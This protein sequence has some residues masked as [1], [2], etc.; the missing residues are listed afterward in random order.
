MAPGRLR[1]LD[2]V[3]ALAVLAVLANH[4]GLTFLPGGFIGV[5]VFFVL[6]GFLITSLL[7][8]ELTATGRIG[9]GAF[10]ARRAR[11]LL[12]AALAMIIAVLAARP[13]FPPD[14]VA[15]L[16]GDAITAAL[17][18]S[19]WRFAL[20]GT[21][22]F[23][24]GGTP[25]P[26]QHTWSLAVEEQFYVV[27]PLLLL[28]CRAVRRRRLLAVALTGAA[29]SA[30]VTY[31]LTGAA[32]PGRVYFG[33]DTRAQELLTGAALAALLAPTWRWLGGGPR[34]RRSPQ[35][36]GRRPLPLLLSLGG[37]AALAA[38]ATT[39]SGA[40]GEFRHGLL[41]G[42]ALATAA[43]LAGV[44]LDSGQP[45]ARLLSA[46]PLAGIG[47]ISYGLYLWHWPVFLVLDGERS[48][49]HGY[50][51]AALRVA[52]TGALAGASFVLIERPAQR[53]R[54][55]ASQVLPAAAAGVA[56][57][58]VVTVCTVP[59][60]VPVVPVAAPGQPDVIPATANAAAP[61]QSTASPPP[62]G[63]APHAT[64]RPGGALHVDVF[65]DSIAWTLMHYLPPTPGMRFTDHTVLG[66]G[67]VTGGP[68]R[69]FGSQ[70]PDSRTCDE[71]PRRW[72][73][74]LDADHPAEAL[75]VVGRWETM[76]HQYQGQWM[77][78]GE[79]RYD[80]FLAGLLSE[81][82]TLLGSTGARVVVATEPYN[83]RGE[84]PDGSLYPEDEPERVTAWNR[85][86]RG[87]VTAHPGTRV[88]DLNHE[89]C[90]NGTFTWTVDGLQVRSDGVHLTPD[91]VRWLTPWLVGQLSQD[92]SG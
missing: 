34:S 23:S 47:R 85:L 81:A 53:V 48:G 84:Q 70:F 1:A 7:Y 45:V 4:A 71:W 65:G 68:Y 38:I 83:R 55:P 3:R 66:C 33:T 39:A 36:A 2:G 82:I 27:W 62:P 15:G 13:L 18:S 31:V 69:Y 29:T 64:V 42:V 91:G 16:R 77:H 63:A 88:L 73:L 74:Q 21:N 10:W 49:L 40:P 8:G 37:L 41:L 57:V 60:G 20:Q 35:P 75:L 58:L 24:H 54:M 26:L 12:P 25:S 50:A 6:S 46:R 90:P 28:A 11:R 89:L 19:N 56:A 86:L 67:I 43:L 72:R 92:E 61:Q 52:V 17:W 76:D 87:V 32:S 51:L 5:D 78:V 59:P 79:P 44:V 14:A 80:S 22:Y 30:L 9:L